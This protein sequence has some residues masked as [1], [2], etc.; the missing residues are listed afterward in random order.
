[1]FSKALEK[2]RTKKIDIKLSPSLKKELTLLRTIVDNMGPVG[3][4]QYLQSMHPEYVF[5]A[6]EA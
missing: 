5:L 2:E 1:M 4:M 3:M 6:R